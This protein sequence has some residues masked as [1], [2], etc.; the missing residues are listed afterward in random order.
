MLIQKRVRVNDRIRSEKIRLIGPNGEQVGIVG[1][2]EGLRQAEEVRLDLVEVAPQ[3]APPVCRIMDFSK[4]KYEQE[5]KE[6]EARRR[7]R[8]IHI[9]ELRLKPKI[10]EHDYQVKVAQAKRFLGRGDRIKV[11]LAFRGREQAHPELG[12]QI[13]ARLATD[14]SGVGSVERGPIPEG[15]FLIMILAAK[16]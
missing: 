2:A 1:V 10:G 4:Y 3:A 5:R 8:V 15:R 12:R 11:T 9:K 14:I 13:L 7:Q 16:S 6:K